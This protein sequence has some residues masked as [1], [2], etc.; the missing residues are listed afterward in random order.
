MKIGHLVQLLI[1]DLWFEISLLIIFCQM[2]N[3]LMFIN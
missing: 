1:A 2:D 3:Y